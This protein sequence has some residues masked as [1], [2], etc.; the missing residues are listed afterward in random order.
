MKIR[1]RLWGGLVI[2]VC[3]L[4]GIVRYGAGKY[5]QGVDDER[6]IRLSHVVE[7]AQLRQD[8]DQAVERM[9]DGAAADELY[10]NWSRD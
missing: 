9:A 8:V 5:A 3:L 2:V 7:S 4:L 10:R 6:K 1:W